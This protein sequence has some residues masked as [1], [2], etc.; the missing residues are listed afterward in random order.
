MKRWIGRVAQTGAL[1]IVSALWSTACGGTESEVPQRT[2]R[3]RDS[4]IAQSALPHA[5]GVGAALRAQDKGDAI[6]ARI[7]SI[8]K[9]VP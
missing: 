9:S 7:D 2:D 3:E 4:L 5:S 6:N 1:V 8:A